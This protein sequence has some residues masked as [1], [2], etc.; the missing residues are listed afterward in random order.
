MP[1][2]PAALALL[3]EAA[4][5]SE[6]DVVERALVAAASYRTGDVIVPA[7]T[8]ETVDLI[9]VRA[10]VDR[11]N[12]VPDASSQAEVVTILPQAGTRVSPLITTLETGYEVAQASEQSGTPTSAAAF[13]D[14]GTAATESTVTF[15]K[16]NDRSRRIAVWVPVWK[17][18]LDDAVAAELAIRQVLREDMAAKLDSVILNG[19]GVGEE[20]KGVLHA[21]WS[22]TSTP[23][24]VAGS[25]LRQDAIVRAVTRVR[26]AKFAGP[27]SVILNPTDHE[28]TVL[29]GATAFVD[30]LTAMGVRQVVSTPYMSAGSGLVGALGLV[31]WYVREPLTITF[32]DSHDDFFTKGKVAILVTLRG[33]LRVVAPGALQVVTS[34]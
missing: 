18:V 21:S 23:R 29:E 2:S 31:H 27:L 24:N 34:L 1:S 25:E 30:K 20:P 5:I 19:N 3:R 22:V 4:G 26:N 14:F 8:R 7:T 6:D 15:S 12:V 9:R 33:T 17:S 10:T 28:E 13:A 32:S 16:N 11:T